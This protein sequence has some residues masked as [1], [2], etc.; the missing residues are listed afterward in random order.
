MRWLQTQYAKRVE[1]ARA[2]DPDWSV[3]D[4]DAW[5]V[6]IVVGVAAGWVLG[7]RM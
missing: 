6:I 7:V 4:L 3:W 2:E 5:L 1:R